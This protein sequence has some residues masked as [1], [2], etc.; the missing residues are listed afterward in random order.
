MTK[1]LIF[2]KLL[3]LSHFSDLFENFRKR[4][5]LMI[6]I[7]LKNCRNLNFLQFTAVKFIFRP[8]RNWDTR[9]EKRV[10]ANEIVKKLL[11]ILKLSHFPDLFEYFRKRVVLMVN[12]RFTGWRKHDFLQLTGAE[13]I[14]RPLRNWD[15]GLEKRVK[16]NEIVKKLNIGKILNF[17]TLIYSKMFENGWFLWSTSD[18][19]VV[20]N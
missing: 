4:W 14:F 5:V 16:F 1:P 17:Y 8:H 7:T 2:G 11:K 12:V 10:K 3:K 9:P 20:Q 6:N 18:L 13:F 15:T 19:K